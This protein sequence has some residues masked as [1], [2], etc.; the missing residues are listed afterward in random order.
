MPER[1]ILDWIG[2]DD[3][4]QARIY[5]R[6]APPAQQLPALADFLADHTATGT[7]PPTL[8][9]YRAWT[10]DHGPHLITAIVAPGTPERTATVDYRYRV[11][12]H[13]LQIT[14][15]TRTGTDWAT[16]AQAD[17]PAT[18]YAHAAQLLAEQAARVRTLTHSQPRPPYAAHL[19]DP[20]A[21]AAAASRHEV[22]AAAAG[23]WPDDPAPL[24]RVDHPTRQP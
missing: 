8:D 23:W 4:I 12:L 16:T 3:Q 15:R 14:A 7:E 6:W 11:R 17:S 5:S 13:P 20:A 9:H 2:P 24:H 1:A 22:N 19:A 10:H 18:L 21:L